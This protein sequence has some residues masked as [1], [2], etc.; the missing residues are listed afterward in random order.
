LPPP[1]PSIPASKAW[2]IAVAAT[3]VMSVSYIDRQTLAAIAPTVRAALHISHTQFGW[4]L[5]AFSLAYLVGAPLA[6]ALLDRTGA[7]RGLVAAVLAWSAVAALHAAVPSLAALFAL[8]ILLG[9]S[10]A[11]SFPGAAQTVTRVLP[12]ERRSAG[13]GV[14]FT[15]SSLGAMIAPSLA[16]GVL[17]SFGWR[18]AFVG[19]ALVG[20][21]WVPAWLWATRRGVIDGPPPGERDAAPAPSRLALAV[22]APVARAVVLVV[23]AAPSIMF[24]L[25]WWSQYLAEAHDLP[26]GELRA[27]LTVPPLFF[28]LGAVGFGV[29]ASRADARDGEAARERTRWALMIAASL[30][31]AVM[32]L[33]P[34]VH[35]PWPA[36][37]CGAVSLAGGGGIFALLTA[38]MLK[39][40]HPSHVSTA[41]GLTASAQSL[42]YVVAN[43]LIGAVVDATHSY[44]TVL[45]VLGAVVPPSVLLWSRWPVRARV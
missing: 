11:P 3:L 35:G 19:T 34:R 23:F 4:V 21:L 38:D 45:L 40:V 7:R 26:Q 41:A 30:L 33:A 27:Y 9:L 29:L 8:R 25:N 36:T 22:T 1:P 32:A 42:A 20:L 2:T 31:C 18:A 24:G 44:D 17:Q 16:I 5:G 14:L 28:D 13:I 39:R 12:A 6:G 43:P 15:G 37:L 10:E